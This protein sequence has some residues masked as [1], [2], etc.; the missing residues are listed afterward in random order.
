MKTAA[1]LAFIV[2][3]AV[4]LSFSLIGISGYNIEYRFDGTYFSTVSG[5]CVI[6]TGNGS[7]Q[8]AL[9]SNDSCVYPIFQNGATYSELGP[10]SESCITLEKKCDPVPSSLKV[11]ATAMEGG[12][13]AS[14]SRTAAISG[15]A[16]NGTKD[17][18]VQPSNATPGNAGIQPSESQGTAWQPYATFLILAVIISLV[19]IWFIRRRYLH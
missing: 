19:S 6:N 3:A 13:R 12:V 8:V 2:F 1:L 9:S 11:I 7:L 16:A 10:D 14:V 4:P 5:A 17:S 15:A 18:Q